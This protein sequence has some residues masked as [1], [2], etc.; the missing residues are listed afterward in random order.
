MGHFW[1]FEA[2]FGPFLDFWNLFWVM[3]LDL[4]GSGPGLGLFGAFFFAFGGLFWAI[5][6]LSEPILDHYGP[7]FG[8]LG[9]YMDHF[10][11]SEPILGHF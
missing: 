10:G 8:G 3:G 9:L 11:L 2:N 1:S 6:G 7:G 5:F 4:W